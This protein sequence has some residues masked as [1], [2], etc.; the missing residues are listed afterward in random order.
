ME[1]KIRTAGSSDTQ[2]YTVVVTSKQNQKG[3]EKR[4]MMLLFLL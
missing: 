4:T 2:L 1:D 3:K